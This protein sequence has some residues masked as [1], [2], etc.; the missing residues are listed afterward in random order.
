MAQQIP[1]SI[2]EQILTKLGSLA[3]QEIGLWS[4]KE[5]YKVYKYTVHHQSCTSQC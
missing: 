5:P 3:V 4:S 2:V 1:F